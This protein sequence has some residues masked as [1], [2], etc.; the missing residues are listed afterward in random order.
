M[1][2]GR[3]TPNA[4]GA[5][6]SGAEPELWR[7]GRKLTVARMLQ[8]KGTS[9][10][11]RVEWKCMGWVPASSGTGGQHSPGV[12]HPPW[13][14]IPEGCWK[15]PGPPP[16]AELT[17]LW[18]RPGG[19]HFANLPGYSQARWSLLHWDTWETR[20]W[21]FGSWVFHCWP[22]GVFEGIWSGDHLPLRWI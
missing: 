6:G 13:G 12:P 11:A 9:W 17:L 7:L 8:T 2:R 15:F 22:W 10:E 1:P 18:L 16:G 21:R 14:Q 3:G 20:W 5:Y 4:R 19:L